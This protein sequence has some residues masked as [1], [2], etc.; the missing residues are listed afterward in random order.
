[1]D[2]NIMTDKGLNH[3]DKCAV[4]YGHLSLQEEK[5]TSSSWGDSKINTSGTRANSSRKSIE[6]DKNGDIDKIGILVEQ[7]IL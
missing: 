5:C 3:F 4:E 6:I 1:M 7:V 2:S